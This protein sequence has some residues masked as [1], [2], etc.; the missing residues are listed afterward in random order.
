[1]HALN[2]VFE[3]FV[4]LG[5]ACQVCHWR[6]EQG[7]IYPVRRLISRVHP[8]EWVKPTYAMVRRTLRN[9]IYSGAYVFGRS[10]SGTMNGGC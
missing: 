9:P 4:E 7:L 3:K 1:M 10:K 6:N 5:S 2:T 8:V